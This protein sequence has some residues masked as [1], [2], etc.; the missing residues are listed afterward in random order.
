M[1]TPKTPELIAE[2]ERIKGLILDEAIAIHREYGPFLLE[3]FYEKALAGRLRKHGLTVLEQVAISVEDHGTMIDLAFRLDLLVNNLV[4]IE[5]KVA[6]QDNVAFHKQLI[7]YLRL[8]KKPFGVLLN[9][10]LPRLIDG[11]EQYAN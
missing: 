5:L 2:G 4:V 3:N 11:Y 8:A 9:F 1:P 7:T 10:G 6:T